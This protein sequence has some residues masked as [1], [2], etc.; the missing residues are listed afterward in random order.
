M[1]VNIRNYQEVTCKY[2]LKILEKKKTC[3]E[4]C[5]CCYYEKTLYQKLKEKGF[6]SDYKT[7]NWWRVELDKNFEIIYTPIKNE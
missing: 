6:F 4:E 7:I 2:L 3:T 1:S 5:R